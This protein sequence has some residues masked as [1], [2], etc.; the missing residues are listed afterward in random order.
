MNPSRRGPST[1]SALSFDLFG[2]LVTVSKTHEPSI[3]V[4]TA[5]EARG[6]DVPADWSHRYS[7]VYLD[8]EPGAEVALVDHI[9]AALR[10]AGRD[11]D[12]DLVDAAVIE[13]F[14]PEVETVPGATAAVETLANRWSIG[15]LSNCS[16]PEIAERAIE[17]SSIDGSLFDAVV[18]SEGC[19]WRKPDERA[20]EAIA[21]A[22]AVEPDDLVHVGDDPIADGGNADFGGISILVDDVPLVDL[23]EVLEGREWI[24]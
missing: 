4:A 19:G 11:V 16:V 9:Q 8:R 12:A 3:A 24:R 20:F 2:T 10:A 6:V 14:D 5:L 7:T 17:R 13:A 1:P 22:L 21:H 15:V 23:P 18:T